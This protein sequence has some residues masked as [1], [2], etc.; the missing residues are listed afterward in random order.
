MIRAFRAHCKHRTFSNRQRA[1]SRGCV[2]AQLRQA[3]SGGTVDSRKRGPASMT[4]RVDAGPNSLDTEFRSP[5]IHWASEPRDFSVRAYRD[6]TTRTQL[7][8]RRLIYL[9]ALRMTFAIEREA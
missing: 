4:R 5:Q 6:T 8:L 9:N 1:A 7:E 2:K 3:Q